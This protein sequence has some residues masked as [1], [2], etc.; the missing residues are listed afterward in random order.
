MREV[1]FP[2]SLQTGTR[3][4]GHRHHPEDL[5]SRGAQSQPDLGSDLFCLGEVF[6]LSPHI[7][8]LLPHRSFWGEEAERCKSGLGTG[9]VLRAVQH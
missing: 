4:H 9:G 1:L 2:L 6:S 7:Q 8:C 5:R 3:G